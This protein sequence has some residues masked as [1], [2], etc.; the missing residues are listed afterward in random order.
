MPRVSLPDFAFRTTAVADLASRECDGLMSVQRSSIDIFALFST[1]HTILQKEQKEGR[2][3]GGDDDCHNCAGRGSSR[4]G[5]GP[6][7]KLV[8]L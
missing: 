1:S 5:E 2:I 4:S 7:E 3:K 8:P 6:L